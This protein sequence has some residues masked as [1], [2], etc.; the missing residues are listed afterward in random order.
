M[1][2]AL[3]GEAS[4]PESFALA[5]APC[6]AFRPLDLMLVRV[7]GADA[8]SFLH[9][10]FTQRV[11]NLGASIRT[12]GYCSPK[13]RLLA[14]VRLWREDD[15]VMM[16]FPA[17]IAGGFLKR[18]RMYV[19]RS[20][21]TFETVDV[22]GL[23]HLSGAEGLEAARALG[24]EGLEALPAA[25]EIGAAPLP[26]RADRAHCP[27]AAGEIVEVPGMKLMGLSPASDLPGFAAGGPRALLRT[28]DP[29][30]IVHLPES[31][32]LWWAA[33]IASGVATVHP[34]TRELFVPQ[35]VNLELVDGVVFSKGC[36][37]G[38]EVVSRVQHIGETNRRA[39]IGRTAIGT[40]PLPG[41]PVF[42][43]EGV[44]GHVVVAVSNGT[45]TVIL[46]SATKTALESGVALSPEGETVQTVELPY[47]YRN[48]LAG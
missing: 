45:E 42:T 47:R 44:A 9:G 33:E 3:P 21:V 5:A 8:V 6:G 35:A 25:G 26:S 41:A 4:R 43:A 27:S 17:S 11:D 19:L 40:A 15:A 30:R 7:T 1:L 29:A 38:Q 18:L 39:A 22:P 2:T 28:T 14:V 32:A 34:E 20:D 36:Y 37:P 48:V 16:L 10:Q 46:Y 23:A 13:G 12:A 24:F 31:S